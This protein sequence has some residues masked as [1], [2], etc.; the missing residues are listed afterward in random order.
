MASFRAAAPTSGKA[1]TLACNI[2][3]IYT[4]IININLFNQTFNGM[5]ADFLGYL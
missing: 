5:I 3:E 2:V 4:I 1:H